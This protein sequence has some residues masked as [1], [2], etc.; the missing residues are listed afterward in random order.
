MRVL[1]LRESR[2]TRFAVALCADRRAVPKRYQPLISVTATSRYALRNR[3][4]ER[5]ARAL[6]N[7]SKWRNPCLT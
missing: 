6:S 1:R 3:R 4:F 2:P 5:K 7:E